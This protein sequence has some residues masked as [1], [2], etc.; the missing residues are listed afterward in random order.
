MLRPYLCREAGVEPVSERFYLA[1]SPK[2]AAVRAALDLRPSYHRTIVVRTM[3]S[4]QALASPC[5]RS[6]TYEIRLG[7]H[8][9]EVEELE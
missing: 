3:A 1:A 2:A 6:R 5:W 4:G 7:Q 8:L 9:R